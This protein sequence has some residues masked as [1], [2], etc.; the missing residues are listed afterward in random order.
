[1][2]KIVNLI[3]LLGANGAGRSTSSNSTASSGA[4]LTEV[5]AWL[6]N[7]IIN[8]ATVVWGWLISFFYMLVKWCLNIIDIFQMFVEKLVGIDAF[9]QEGGLS[10]VEKLEDTDLIIRFITNDVVIDIFKTIFV[11]G[12]VLLVIFSILALIKQNYESATT[13]GGDGVKKPMD[14][15]KRAGKAIFMCLLVPFLL[16]FGI[17]G[18]NAVLASICNSIKGDNDLTIG[19][20][21]FTAS[22]YEANKFREYASDGLRV[23]ITMSQATEVV[24]PGEYTSTEDM[25]VLFYK[26]ATGKIYISAISDSDWFDA[27]VVNFSE[28]SGVLSAEDV[29][30]DASKLQGSVAFNEFKSDYDNF[31]RAFFEENG[32]IETLSEKGLLDPIIRSVY[33]S[34]WTNNKQYKNLTYDFSSTYKTQKEVQFAS[35]DGESQMASIVVNS[36]SYTGFESF[37][38]MELEYYVMADLIDYAIEHNQ[39]FYY[40]N[41]N[42]DAILWSGIELDPEEEKVNIGDYNNQFAIAKTDSDLGPYYNAL[43]Y[44]QNALKQEGIDGNLEKLVQ[45]AFG[46]SYEL[47]SESAFMVRYYNG[48]N[49]LYWSEIDATSEETGATYIICIKDANG[50]FIPVTQETTGFKSS[51]LADDYTGA[52]VARGVFKEE[53]FIPKEYCLPTEIMEQIVDDYGN[54]LINIDQTSPFALSDTYTDVQTVAGVMSEFCGKLAN[55]GSPLGN[56]LEGAF[57]LAENIELGYQDLIQDLMVDQL[58][59]DDK[60]TAEEATEAGKA[61]GDRKG[62]LLINPNINGFT[63]HY[64]NATDTTPSSVT[65]YDS[66][67]R[68]ISAG[69]G[70]ADSTS[71][72]FALTNESNFGKKAYVLLQK[73]MFGDTVIPYYFTDSVSLGQLIGAIVGSEISTP[74]HTFLAVEYTY[75]NIQIALNKSDGSTDTFRMLLNFNVT[76]IAQL[77]TDGQVT[78]A[79][80]GEFVITDEYGIFE[81]A[82]VHVEKVANLVISNG[83]VYYAN[84]TEF[85]TKSDAKALY[86][87]FADTYTK[88]AFWTTNVVGIIGNTLAAK[89]YRNFQTLLNQASVSDDV[90]SGKT[91]FDSAVAED[92]ANGTNT[93]G[94]GVVAGFMASDFRAG[95][96]AMITEY[97]KKYYTV[98]EEVIV[99]ELGDGD[100]ETETE[101][102]EDDEKDPKISGKIEFYNQNNQKMEDETIKYNAKE[103]VED[104]KFSIRVAVVG[105]ADN[106]NNASYA[107]IL[108]SA[109]TSAYTI[110]YAGDLASSGMLDQ[111]ENWQQKYFPNRAL[112]DD[113]LRARQVWIYTVTYDIGYWKY[114]SG[115]GSSQKTVAVLGTTLSNATVEYAGKLNLSGDNGSSSSLDTTTADNVHYVT[116]KNNSAYSPALGKY[117][118]TPSG[119]KNLISSVAENTTPTGSYNGIGYTLSYK[120]ATSGTYKA[121]DHSNAERIESYNLM[122]AEN[123]AVQNQ[124]EYDN[125]YIYFLRGDLNWTLLFD[126]CINL[127]TISWSPLYLKFV[128]RCRLGTS[129]DYSENVIYRLQN[130]QFYLDYNFRNSTGIAIYNLFRMSSINP[131]ILIFSTVMVFGILWNVIWG[132]IRRIYDILLLFIMLPAVT[133]TMPMDEGSRFKKWKDELIEKIF[134]A[135]SILITLNLYFVLVPI[136]KDVTSGLITAGDIPSTIT[137]MFSSISMGMTSLTGAIGQF[138]GNI[139]LNSVLLSSELTMA[140][141]AV[142]GHVNVIV[143]IMF[144]LVLTTMLKNGEVLIRKILELGQLEDGVAGE[145]IGNAKDI[146]NKAKKPVQWTAGKV[147]NLAKGAVKLGSKGFSKLI[148]AGNPANPMETIMDSSSD[149]ATRTEVSSTA[150]P[151]SS[152]LLATGAPA[153]DTTAVAPYDAPPEN[154]ENTATE[155]SSTRGTQIPTMVTEDGFTLPSEYE[156]ISAM[157][158]FSKEE[159]EQL[160]ESEKAEE[161]TEERKQHIAMME[162]YLDQKFNKNIEEVKDDVKEKIFKS[163]NVEK[164]DFG[165]NDVQE[166]EIFTELNVLKEKYKGVDQDK[167]DAVRQATRDIVKTSFGVKQG[168]MTED[169]AREK[170]NATMAELDKTLKGAQTATEET[171]KRTYESP[172]AESMAKHENEPT[173]VQKEKTKGDEELD[174]LHAQLRMAQN[175]VNAQRFRSEE[176]RQ[177]AIAHLSEEIKKRGGMAPNAPASTPS[178][179]DT[180][181]MTTATPATGGSSTST[182]KPKKSVGKKIAKGVGIVAA[183]LL[184]PPPV[185]LAVLGGKLAVKGT[186]KLAGKTTSFLG[187]HPQA[188]KFAKIA[189]V[190]IVGGPVGLATMGAIKGTKTIVKKIKEKRA[191]NADKSEKDDVVHMTTATPVSEPKQKKETTRTAPQEN[192]TP[193]TH[194]KSDNSTPQKKAYVTPEA[195][196]QERK[197]YVAPKAVKEEIT[198]AVTEAKKQAVTEAKKT[199]QT[200]AKKAVTAVVPH[201]TQTAVTE[202]KKDIAS[203]NKKTEERLKRVED[204]QKK[205]RKV[206]RAVYMTSTP[207]P[208]GEGQKQVKSASDNLSQHRART[209]AKN[210]MNKKQ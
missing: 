69:A 190:G 13:E 130:G 26:L 30:V 98:H 47:V 151:R 74:M 131:F 67:G 76:N 106:S 55:F 157:D 61:E 171:K 170:M 126:F 103:Y 203:Q 7:A 117:I 100:T 14:V 32:R 200:E 163:E 18:S 8:V 181:H 37:A 11:L 16:I 71:T 40:V 6:G 46:S 138:A 27:N 41:A 70:Y 57:M 201:A 25:Q 118:L 75:D 49:R 180:V 186:K 91:D 94:E 110:P 178:D 78:L 187:D 43:A 39:T 23:P 34:N 127:P 119:V 59:E 145:A 68:K 42:S 58:N 108:G 128:F 160:I 24:R 183:T 38:T 66:N 148:T 2:G 113:D 19:G 77:G 161:Q 208:T 141:Q 93:A 152:S 95:L 158:N 62:N 125:V 176:D 85:F 101:N 197:T 202:V 167:F 116:V 177:N 123:L 83:E 207:E 17:L 82:N 5:L 29:K 188:K 184:V 199:A 191:Q 105:G 10:A 21:I 173:V 132:L 1:M 12:L 136:V 172:T 111:F 122:S 112:T 31:M 144:F 115:E 96:S 88:E 162:Q 209:E 73:T 135:Y 97:N 50:N 22:S 166:N 72:T 9:N 196:K 205:P 84:G 156:F 86:S 90:D 169:E 133:S 168:S 53:N 99:D 114:L 193:N 194:P 81:G 140:E 198:R 36:A 15:L 129:Y 154:A 142:L 121:F 54:E 149:R 64:K 33:V 87:D 63:Y 174:Q 137:G 182:S 179:D 124:S 164:F 109:G 185:T 192:K 89:Q 3:N 175:D 79:K 204:A 206:P 60:Y 139:G 92:V 45:S 155:Q 107:T 52:I 80:S 147:K 150:E 134:S 28:W 56:L 146:I 210:P 65:F 102:T 20:L 4:W 51:F 153:V 44:T 165:K 143:Y 35:V 189:A 48:V 120:D 104:E 159:I 195:E